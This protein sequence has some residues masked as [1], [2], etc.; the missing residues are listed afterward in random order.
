MLNCN[1]F[2]QL[3]A[4]YMPQTR[5]FGHCSHLLYPQL[6]VEP[7]GRRCLQSGD[8]GIAT[9]VWGGVMEP[10][11]GQNPKPCILLEIPQKHRWKQHFDHKQ[12]SPQN[13]TLFCMSCVKIKFLG[14]GNPWMEQW[15]SHSENKWSLVLASMRKE[16]N[17]FDP[18][19]H[20]PIFCC[21][22][23]HISSL[24]LI[25]SLKFSEKKN[26]PLSRNKTFPWA[27]KKVQIKWIGIAILPKKGNDFM[28]WKNA[29]MPPILIEYIQLQQMTVPAWCFWQAQWR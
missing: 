23:L 26:I 4:K 17:S 2:A 1:S 15:M 8:L 28:S 24:F 25:N 27:G 29:Q 19:H 3:Q 20:T 6:G 12:K 18:T 11:F 7:T 9:L 14:E 13:G 21:V 16:L 22:T 10:N 5:M